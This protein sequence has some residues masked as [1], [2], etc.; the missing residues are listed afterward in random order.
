MKPKD[1]PDERF[2]RE[3][4]PDAV[5]SGG[6]VTHLVAVEDWSAEP[7]MAAVPTVPLGDYAEPYPGSTVENRKRCP[8]EPE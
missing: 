6:G 8:R 5:K 2:L 1:W 4:Y 7:G 3:K